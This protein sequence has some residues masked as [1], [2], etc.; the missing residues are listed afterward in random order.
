MLGAGMELKNAPER[1]VVV[2]HE[3][4]KSRNMPKL[5]SSSEAVRQLIM[6]TASQPHVYM[7]TPGT[8]LRFLSKDSTCMSI[9]GQLEI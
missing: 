9:L 2:G 3:C 7:R 1:S 6:C 4:S 5:Y 8:A